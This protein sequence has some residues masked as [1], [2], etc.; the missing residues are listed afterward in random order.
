MQNSVYPGACGGDEIRN[1]YSYDQEGHR[2][3]ITEEI[4]GQGSPPPPP[5]IALPSE[6][7]V[8]MPRSVSQHDQS[9]RLTETALL[10]PSGRII[11][12]N[13][14]AYDEKGRLIETVGR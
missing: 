4:R 14:Y 5:A 8:G 13:S 7:E 12:K 1:T 9:G 11:Y 2:T 10:R 3:T 6:P